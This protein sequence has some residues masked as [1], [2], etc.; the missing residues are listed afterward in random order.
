MKLGRWPHEPSRLRMKRGTVHVREMGRWQV[1][2]EVTKHY[3]CFSSLVHAPGGMNYCW[4]FSYGVLVFTLYGCTRDV[5]G[6]SFDNCPLFWIHSSA[7][8]KQGVQRGELDGAWRR[9]GTGPCLLLWGLGCLLSKRIWSEQFKR[10]LQGFPDS[11]VGK[12]S[13]CNAGDPSSI[14]GSG[15]S[16]GE[17]KPPT[18]VF[19]LFPCGSAG[20]EST[21]NAGDLGLIPG[22]GRSPGEGKGY[23]LQYSGLENCMDYSPW[24]HKELNTTEWLSL[25]RDRLCSP[26][27]KVNPHIT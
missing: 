22:L 25:S 4:I 19:L 9:A 7:S 13:A 17:G 1:W 6:S 15:R 5:Y 8:W 27:W 10:P 3:V 26:F 20:K 16:A 23:G 21:C 2:F 11:S 12:E 18:P 14:P 24:T